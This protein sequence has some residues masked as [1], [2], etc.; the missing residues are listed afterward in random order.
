MKMKQPNTAVPIK[1]RQFYLL[2]I[3][4]AWAIIEIPLQIMQHNLKW[5]TVAIAVSILILEVG[6]FAYLKKGSMYRK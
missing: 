1:S 4:L 3:L 5:Y 2:H 6:L